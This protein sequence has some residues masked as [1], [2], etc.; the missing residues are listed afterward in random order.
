MSPKR[1]QN[2]R[3][4]PPSGLLIVR[5]FALYEGNRRVLALLLGVMFVALAIAFVGP[6]HQIIDSVCSNPFF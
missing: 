3:L 4:T 5:T 1:N 6:G 2:K